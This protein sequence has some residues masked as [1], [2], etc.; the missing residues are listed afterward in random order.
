M[1]DSINPPPPP[2]YYYAHLKFH[3][4]ET[5]P[6]AFWCTQMYFTMFLKSQLGVKYHIYV[7]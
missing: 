5:P 3:F 4:P 1:A 2:L 6:K 7:F